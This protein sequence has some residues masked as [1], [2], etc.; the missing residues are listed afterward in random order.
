M[1]KTKGTNA[2]PRKGN[3]ISQE[4]KINSPDKNKGNLKKKLLHEMKAYWVYVVYLTLIFGA[5]TWYR[6]LI[7]AD[8]GIT[9][10]DYGVAL[11]EALIFAKVIMI[12]DLLHLGRGFEHKPLI[13]PILLKTA[14]FTLFVGLFTIIEHVIKSLVQGKGL[15]AGLVDFF[16][17]G[18]YELLAGCLIIFVAFIPFFALREL[19][20]MLGGEGKILE[21]IFKSKDNQ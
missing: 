8:V 1:A 2:Y 7:L 14:I 12:G 17:K 18:S 10:T 13:F 3:S 5:F 6:R 19:S 11:I 21:L 4:E 9:Y 16:G 20:R 15:T